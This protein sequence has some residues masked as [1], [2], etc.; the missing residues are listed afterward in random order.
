LTDA[1]ATGV[2]G[3]GPR[4]KRRR[5]E[6]RS[7]DEGYP[8]GASLGFEPLAFG[9]FKASGLLRDYPYFSTPARFSPAGAENGEK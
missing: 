6:K 4:R 3:S 7:D 1:G 8:F 9:I 5:Y 2:A